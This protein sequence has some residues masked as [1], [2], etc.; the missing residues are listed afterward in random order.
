MYIWPIFS[1]IFQRARQHNLSN[2]DQNSEYLV[3]HKRP[4]AVKCRY[5]IHMVDEKCMFQSHAPS[6]KKTVNMDDPISESDM[7]GVVRKTTYS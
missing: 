7:S 5:Y 3:P 2:T 4:K 1:L 6:L